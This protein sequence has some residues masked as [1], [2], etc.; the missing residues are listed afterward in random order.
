MFVRACVYVYDSSDKYVIYTIYK[1]EHC[2]LIETLKLQIF[3]LS[4]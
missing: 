1:I 4:I 3:K 2:G